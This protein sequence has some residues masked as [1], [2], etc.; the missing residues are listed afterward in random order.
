[1]S[2][3]AWYTTRIRIRSSM[4]P[5]H[6]HRPILLQDTLSRFTD[7]DNGRQNRHDYIC[8]LYPR[9]HGKTWWMTEHLLMT[10]KSDDP[11]AWEFQKWQ[12]C[13]NHLGKE[14]HMYGGLCSAYVYW[15]LKRFWIDGR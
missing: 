4:M 8:G 14:I 11:S 9:I 3:E 10:E 13:L 1:M 15:Y 5:K 7:L 12:Y 6:L 2:P